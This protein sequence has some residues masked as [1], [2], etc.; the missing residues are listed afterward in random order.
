[1]QKQEVR[2]V[3]DEG[4]LRVLDGPG[5]LAHYRHVSDELGKRFTGCR[6]C[7][8][9]SASPFVEAGAVKVVDEVV[10]SGGSDEKRSGP[11]PLR[12]GED[13]REESQL[14]EGEREVRRLVR[15]ELYG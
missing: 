15:E 5:I 4:D 12:V 10:E 13:E 6:Y 3:H 8:S 9:R 2:S 7:T 1:M 11:S 14:S